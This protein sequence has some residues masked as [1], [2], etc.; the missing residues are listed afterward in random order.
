MLR[1]VDSVAARAST[2]SSQCWTGR[3][4]RL[5]NCAA[6]ETAPPPR[7]GP[8]V[9]GCLG[10]ETTDIEFVFGIEDAARWRSS[11]QPPPLL[12]VHLLRSFAITSPANARA[13]LTRCLDVAHLRRD[14][15]IRAC[16]R[17][18][19]AR[20]MHRARASASRKLG[21]HD[22]RIHYGCAGNVRGLIA[23][24]VR[25]N[26]TAYGMRRPNAFSCWRISRIAF[27]ASAASSCDPCTGITTRSARLIA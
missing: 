3:G 9:V 27:A 13:L 26:R 2:G 5:W 18:R 4:S 14:R 1:P 17:R 10:R 6:S 20:E 19:R 23:V 16:H 15:A 24:L 21:H 8:L 22:P 7:A 12:S 11:T 25:V